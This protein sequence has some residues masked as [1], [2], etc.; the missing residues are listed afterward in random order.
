M[1]STLSVLPTELTLLRQPDY[2][3]LAQLTDREYA[4]LKLAMLNRLGELHENHQNNPSMRP[5]PATGP[6]GKPLMIIR[7][8]EPL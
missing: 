4:R 2:A 8:N 5:P 7:G 6:V 1:E 3:T